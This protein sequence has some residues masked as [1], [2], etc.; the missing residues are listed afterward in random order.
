MGKDYIWRL[1]RNDNELG[2]AAEKLGVNI[3]MKYDAFILEKPY[4][5]FDVR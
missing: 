1:T 3:E 5:R 2:S 4:D